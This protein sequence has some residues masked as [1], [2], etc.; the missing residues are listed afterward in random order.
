M[1][2]YG[3][4]RSHGGQEEEAPG[5]SG[6]FWRQVQFPGTNH[7]GLNRDKWLSTGGQV[8]PSADV[9]QRLKMFLVVTNG[10]GGV[11]SYWHL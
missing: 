7:E 11:G 10:E 1:V 5:E 6:R 8:C 2:R 9:C 4:L 3:F